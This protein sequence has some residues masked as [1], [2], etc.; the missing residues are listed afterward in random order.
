MANEAGAEISNPFNAHIAASA[1]RAVLD[2]LNSEG[3]TGSQVRE[4]EVT[5]ADALRSTP[6]QTF[7]SDANS[8]IQMLQSS[9]IEL[10]KLV[11]AGHL[12]DADQKNLTDAIGG[13]TIQIASL[14]IAIKDDALPWPNKFELLANA[15]SSIARCEAFL[16]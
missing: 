4:A 11:N 1:A 16:R 3:E 6:A 8:A 14:N 2:E 10:A 15:Q 13:L 7:E 12:T 5:K 9:S